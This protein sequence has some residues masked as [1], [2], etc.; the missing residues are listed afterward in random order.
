MSDEKKYVVL[1]NCKPQG[2]DKW[3]FKRSCVVYDNFE[4]AL[5]HAYNNV[6]NL[7]DI[8]YTMSDSGSFNANTVVA[9]KD[10]VK[11]VIK[12]VEVEQMYKE[13]SGWVYPQYVLYNHAT[14][15]HKFILDN[16]DAKLIASAK[17]LAFADDENKLTPHWSGVVRYAFKT[18][19]SK[20]KTLL[21]P[22]YE[23]IFYIN[24]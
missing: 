11:K 6:N 21:G 18:I 13:G 15:S 10:D 22:T 19:D 3:V 5:M 7:S 14:C 9:T 16:I 4:D 12:I 23:S 2:Y 17:A 1:V 8:G 20:Q 24:E